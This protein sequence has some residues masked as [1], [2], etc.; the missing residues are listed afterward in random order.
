MYQ[1]V[2][3]D[4]SSMVELTLMLVEYTR[5]TST[6]VWNINN[7][8]LYVYVLIISGIAILSVLSTSSNQQCLSILTLY[9]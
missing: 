4:I 6:F 8:L 7:A 1:I 2:L 3:Y 5:K 9:I